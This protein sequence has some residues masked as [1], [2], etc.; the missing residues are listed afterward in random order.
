MFIETLFTITKIW[1]QPKYVSTNEW[2]KHIWF[3]HTIGYY[4]SLIKKILLFATWMNLD[5]IMLSET[6]QTQKEK[7][8][9]ISYVDYKKVKYIEAE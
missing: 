4:L 6:S 5:V 2:I 7:Y 1:N 3:I 9:M 8:C